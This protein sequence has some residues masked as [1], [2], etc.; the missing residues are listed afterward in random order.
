MEECRFDCI[1]VLICLFVMLHIII[2]VPHRIACKSTQA[3]KNSAEGDFLSDEEITLYGQRKQQRANKAEK[4]LEKGGRKRARTR[5][6][7]YQGGDS[8][9]DADYSDDDRV[10]HRGKHQDYNK[11]DEAD[12]ADVVLIMMMMN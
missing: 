10:K 11:D 7:N 9:A 3:L 5:S 12:A 1:R 2:F 8:D 6:S 4:Y